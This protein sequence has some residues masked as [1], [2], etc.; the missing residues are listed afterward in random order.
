MNQSDLSFYR[1]KQYKIVLSLSLAIFFYSFLIFFLPFGVDN[2]NP[3]HQYTS[4]F[5]FEISK[6]S[7]GIL[8]L[9]LVNEFILRPV[10]VKSVSLKNIIGWSIWTLILLS[11]LT[12]VIYNYLGNWHDHSLTSYA[13]FIVN[14]SAVLIFPMVGVFFLYRYRTLQYKMEHILTT[15]DRFID[16]NQLI[17]FVGQGAKDQITLSLSNFLYGK[18]QNNYVELYYLEQDELKKFLIRSSLQNLLD[19]IQS[20]AIV[21][22]HRSYIANLLHVNAI[23]GARQEMT[24]F[25]DPIDILVPVS[26]SYRTEMLHLL[27]ELKNFG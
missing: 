1:T 27:K 20:K 7:A 25:L 22:T 4:E 11:S 2:Y 18:A 13:G 12:Y 14:T 17:N 23:K 15:K 8:L 21:R 19:G 26:K 3:N 6:F 24:V 10:L 9:S 5:L 16:I